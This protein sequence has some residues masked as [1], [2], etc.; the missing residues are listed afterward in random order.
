MALTLF[1]RLTGGYME[2]LKCTQK[3]RKYYE[4]YLLNYNIWQ[5]SFPPTFKGYLMSDKGID[6]TRLGNNMVKWR[7]KIY[8]SKTIIV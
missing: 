2:S 1:G 3:Q 8:S 4:N 6:I 5:L 7:R